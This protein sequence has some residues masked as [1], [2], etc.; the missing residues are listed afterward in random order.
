[1]CVR[2]FFEQHL[3]RIFPQIVDWWVS[4]QITRRTLLLHDAATCAIRATVN[5]GMNFVY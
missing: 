3:G 5:T 2:L 4:R 1:M